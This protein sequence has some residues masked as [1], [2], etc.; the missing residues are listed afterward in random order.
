M[1]IRNHSTGEQMTFA[2]TKEELRIGRS[3][4]VEILLHDPFVSRV[5]GKIVYD[6]GKYFFFDFNSLNGT[7]VNGRPVR[8]K[9]ME[10]LQDG[11]VITFGSYE[12]LFRLASPSYALA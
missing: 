12:M 5:Q 1:E 10:P 9:T 2:L 11:D 7:C 8:R 3:G 4:N 6:E